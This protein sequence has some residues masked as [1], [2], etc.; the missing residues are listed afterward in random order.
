MSSE[1]SEVIQRRAREN[2]PVGNKQNK[3]KVHPAAKGQVQIRAEDVGIPHGIFREV[4]GE[5]VSQL[6]IAQI[7]HDAKGVV[8]TNMD[9]AKPYLA[10]GNPVSSRGLALLVIDANASEMT[11]I[12]AE[13]RFPARCETTQEPIL[14]KAYMIQLGRTMIQRNQPESLPA[15]EV[16]ANTVFRILVFRDEL[17]MPWSTFLEKPV[18]HVIQEF[19]ALQTKDGGVSPI[20]DCWDRQY[21]SSKLERVK[22][23]EASVFIVSFRIE[24]NGIKELLQCS[25]KGAMYVE[26][27]VDTGKAPC[28][29]FRVIW[30]NRADKPQ[31]R[32]ALQSTQAEASLVRSGARYGIRV[33]SENAA[34]VHS[35]HKPSTPFLDSAKLTAFQVGPFPYGATKQT[36]L[37]TFQS[38]NW[39]ARPV[40]PYGRGVH[41][42]GLMWLVHAMSKP[43]YE[44]YNLAHSDVIVSELPKKTRGDSKGS[45]DIQGSSR[46]LEAL[47]VPAPPPGGPSPGSD[48]W[49]TNDPW[50][51]WTS[52]SAK[53]SPTSQNT[54]V[55][56]A[57]L[58]R[59]TAHVEQRVAQSFAKPDASDDELMADTTKVHDLENRLT[60]LEAQVQ[61]NHAEQQSNAR[62]LS[63][64]IQGVQTQVDAQSAQ[65][66]QHIDS[67]LSEQLDHIERI[68]NAKKP[69]NE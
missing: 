58:A 6:Q 17:N 12:G 40:Q 67:K 50:S 66:K 21:V 65:F 11:G 38:W 57:E 14:L 8:V 60:R 56:P 15:V 53:I 61:A 33:T 22:A 31:A 63:T 41:A 3:Q 1:L 26:P 7:H 64:Q 20:V 45:M 18:K 39:Q 28:D 10:C 29:Q 5:A 13:I 47:T 23:S 34:T 43:A 52:K 44:V 49:V 55:T 48:P 24:G 54:S 69:R 37:K 30:L 51:S 25:G 2:R 19:P 35:Q 46:T 59:I 42:Q 62:E 4:Q 9:Q 68:L 36:I 16:V 32:L 27:R